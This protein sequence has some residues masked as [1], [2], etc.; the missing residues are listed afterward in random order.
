M[1]HMCYFSH[2]PQSSTNDVK[3]SL[4]LTGVVVHALRPGIRLFLELHPQKVESLPAKPV[5]LLLICASRCRWSCAI[6]R[7]C[8]AIGRYDSSSKTRQDACCE[9]EH[10][11]QRGRPKPRRKHAR[12]F[13]HF[14]FKIRTANMKIVLLSALSIASATAALHL[15]GADLQVRAESRRSARRS[16]KMLT[17]RLT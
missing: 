7:D 12:D 2:R 4:I 3:P 1:H 15:R 6:C 16:L 13:T 8:R 5:G 10:P 9:P 11:R 17:T 14:P